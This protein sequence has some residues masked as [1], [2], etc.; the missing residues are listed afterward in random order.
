MSQ[1]RSHTVPLLVTLMPV[2]NLA[3]SVRNINGEIKQ[4]VNKATAA[5]QYALDFCPPNH[6]NTV[7]STPVLCVTGR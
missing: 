1:R 5:N 3:K 6:S 4:V 7:V 2:V